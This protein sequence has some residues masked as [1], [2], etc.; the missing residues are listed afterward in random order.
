LGGALRPTQTFLSKLATAL[1]KKADSKTTIDFFTFLYADFYTEISTFESLARL[2]SG[3]SPILAHVVAVL[4]FL[5]IATTAIAPLAK[6]TDVR[7]LAEFASIS[8]VTERFFFL[9]VAAFS[10]SEPLYVC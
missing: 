1:P 3:F 10:H 2:L 8:L 7:A 4:V 9:L 6:S 5:G